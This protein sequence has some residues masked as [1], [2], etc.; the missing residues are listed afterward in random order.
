MIVPSSG[1]DAGNQPRNLILYGC[2][3]RAPVVRTIMLT[4]NWKAILKRLDAEPALDKSD[5]AAFMA[6]SF[7]CRH[8]ESPDASDRQTVGPVT[9]LL[10]PLSSIVS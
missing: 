8:T 7:Q 1:K 2:G 9:I 10:A 3:I 5:D 4:Q 6:S